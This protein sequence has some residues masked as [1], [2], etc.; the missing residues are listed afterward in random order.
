MAFCRR[1][2]AAR[3]LRERRPASCRDIPQTLSELSGCVSRCAPRSERARSKAWDLLPCVPVYH[4]TTTRGTPIFSTD[5]RVRVR[6]FERASEVAENSAC[7]ERVR[8]QP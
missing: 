1:K 2:H 5:A 4:G 7:L 3:F 6:S 8:L